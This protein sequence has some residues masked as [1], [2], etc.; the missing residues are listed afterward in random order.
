MAIDSVTQGQIT[1]IQKL[2]KDLVKA[3]Q[4]ALG[5]SHGNSLAILLIEQGILLAVNVL[6]LQV[7]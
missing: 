7:K 1:K 4:D 6:S 2:G 3:I 5:P